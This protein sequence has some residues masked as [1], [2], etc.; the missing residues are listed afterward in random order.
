MGK[1]DEGGA[2]GQCTGLFSLLDDL[3]CTI[4]KKFGSVLRGSIE[5]FDVSTLNAAQLFPSDSDTLMD[6]DVDLVSAGVWLPLAATFMSDTSIQMAVFSPGIATILQVS[7]LWAKT[8][9]G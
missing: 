1:L 3:A 9:L 2:R 5:I 6:V 8:I 7:V 4:A